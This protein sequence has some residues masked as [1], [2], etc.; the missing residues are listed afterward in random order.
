APCA[1]AGLRVARDREQ[2]P[3]CTA[4]TRRRPGA[5][6]DTPAAAL[7]AAGGARATATTRAQT[8]AAGSAATQGQGP[9]VHLHRQ[10]A[11][12]RGTTSTLGRGVHRQG[13]RLRR[14]ERSGDQSARLLPRTRLLP[15]PGLSAAAGDTQRQ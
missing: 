13:T 14:P 2:L 12:L 11:L 6:A 15:R 4:A 10:H 1:V 9:A 3:P 5:R 8:C 7:A